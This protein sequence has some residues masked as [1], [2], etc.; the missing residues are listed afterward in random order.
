M[1]T[2]W[3]APKTLRLWVMAWLLMAMGAALAAPLMSPRRLE[4]ACAGTGHAV[5][6]VHTA[7]GLQAAD[8]PGTDCPLCLPCGMPPPARHSAAP[9][10]LPALQDAAL[11][12]LPLTPPPLRQRPPARAPPHFFH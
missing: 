5:L 10:P 2:S 12:P 6:L 7:D 11:E 3:Q 1:Q 8:A 9:L 4:L